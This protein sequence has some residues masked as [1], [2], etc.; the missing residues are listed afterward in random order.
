MS[1]RRFKQSECLRVERSLSSGSV[2]LTRFRN[3]G[4]RHQISHREQL[5]S[6]K[7]DSKEICH[8][9]T[10]VILAYC[11]IAVGNQNDERD[12]VGVQH[13]QVIGFVQNEDGPQQ[14][15]VDVRAWGWGVTQ[16]VMP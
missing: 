12:R 3:S 9:G 10:G 7:A 13:P 8:Q 5:A 6:P 16:W 1:G 15:F 14:S 11:R 2:G 4:K